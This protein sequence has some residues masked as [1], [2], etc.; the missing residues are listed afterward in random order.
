VEF[1][2]KKYIG[3]FSIL[4]LA[5]FT[6]I[7][8]NVAL[9]ADENS[10][11]IVIDAEFGLPN[12]TSAQAISL[13]AQ[14]AVKDI[15]ASGLLKGR[16]LQIERSDNRGV[17]A[18][19]VDNLSKMAA[20]K[21]V[22]AVM[23][24]KFSPVY[25]E[26]RPVADQLGII[27]LDP[28]GSAD[29]IAKMGD[30]TNWAFRLSLTDQ[31]AAT[32]FIDEAQKRSMDHIG[33]IIPNTA[34]GR[35]NSEALKKAAAQKNI[36]INAE[37]I[38]NWGDKSLMQQYQAMLDAKVGLVVMVA[39]ENEGALLVREMANLPKEKR[40]P[41]LAHWGITGGNFAEMTNGLIA[42]VDLSVIQTFSF[43]NSI[44]DKATSLIPRILE[45]TRATGIDGIKSSVGIAQA[46]DL[47][48]LFA[49]AMAKADSTDRS[50][51]RNA[52]ENIDAFDGVIKSYSRPFSKDNHNAPLAD[53]LFFAQ[54]SD[55]KDPKPLH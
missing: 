53:Q 24:G 14:L 1:K 38:Y 10:A 32:A 40:L 18:I 35:S 42:N 30:T 43:Y 28:W 37:A 31:W 7:Q 48:W 13:G 11:I 2:V 33:V 49:I 20:R 39:N 4:Y 52:L 9:R 22:V 15:E 36:Q 29:G 19:G 51:I 34:W 50:S 23:G 6:L 16:R 55:A 46:Y 25:I 5:I 41:I 54:Y 12:S 27:L 3:Y 8:S 21:E 17:P 45:E 26:Q 44:N 47:T